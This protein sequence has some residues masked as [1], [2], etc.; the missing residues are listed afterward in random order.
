M[1]DL[2][3]SRHFPSFFHDPAVLDRVPSMFLV[4]AAV[5][6]VMQLAGIASIQDPPAEVRW[7]RSVASIWD[8]SAEVRWQGETFVIES[9]QVVLCSSRVEIVW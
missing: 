7:H 1:F 3:F 2:H 8:P 4:L 6:G 9:L 5:Y